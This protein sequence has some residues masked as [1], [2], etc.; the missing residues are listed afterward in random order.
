MVILKFP[1]NNNP[2]QILLVGSELFLDSS[3]KEIKANIYSVRF[4][5]WSFFFI[6]TSCQVLG[7]FEFCIYPIAPPLLLSWHNVSVRKLK[8]KHELKLLNRENSSTT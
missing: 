2:K 3:G 4:E 6:L 8:L 5:W 1:Y 7:S